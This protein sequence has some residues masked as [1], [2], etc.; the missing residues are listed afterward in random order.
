MVTIIFYAGLL[1]KHDVIA[2]NVI[3]HSVYDFRVKHKIRI[4]T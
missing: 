3:S 2:H 4:V 1:S